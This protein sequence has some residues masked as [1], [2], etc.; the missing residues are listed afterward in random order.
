MKREGLIKL[1]NISFENTGRQSV[2]IIFL[3]LQKNY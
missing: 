3:Q 1:V 2:F